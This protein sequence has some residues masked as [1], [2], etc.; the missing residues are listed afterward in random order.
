MEMILTGA[1]VGAT[2]AARIGLVHRVVP[3][4]ALMREAR[5]LARQLA[6]QEP[7]PMRHIINRVNRHAEGPSELGASHDAGLLGLLRSGGCSTR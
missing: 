1:R 4:A 7:I 6:S 3:A 5:A 2:E